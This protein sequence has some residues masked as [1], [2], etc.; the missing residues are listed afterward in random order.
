MNGSKL[1]SNY[2]IDEKLN[3]LEKENA[4]LL[5]SGEEII[6]VVGMRTSE[7]F[8]ISDKTKVI[9]QIKTTSQN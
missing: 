6:W 8:K 4:W 7:K 1:L 5:I 9:Y 3:L 2:F